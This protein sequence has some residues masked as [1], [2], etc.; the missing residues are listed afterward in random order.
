[1]N[2][3][4][5]DDSLGQKDK[6]GLKEKRDSGLL[7]NDQIRSPQLQ[8]ITH[9]GEN[10]GVIS[11]NDALRM[12]EQAGLDLVMIAEKGKDGVPVAKVMNVGKV[13]YE[14]KKKLSEAKKKQKVIQIKEIKLRPTI[15]VHDYQ[16]KINH[17]VDFL[18]SGK[19][20]KITIFFRGREGITKQERGAELFRKVNSTFE[21]LGLMEHI[22]QERDVNVGQVWSR[23]YYLKDK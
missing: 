1:M 22:V 13:L 6:R 8:V 15:G 4:L 18:K 7:V 3:M 10:I 17:V 23:V 9:E 16:T 5:K 20:V 12:A 11:R 2:K 21:E 19:H 14:K